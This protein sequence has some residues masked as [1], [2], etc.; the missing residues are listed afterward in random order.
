MSNY[1]IIG[2]LGVIILFLIILHKEF[3]GH[4]HYLPQPRTLYTHKF[5][6]PP[7][8]PEIKVNWDPYHEYY[9]LMQQYNK[10]VE[11]R[12]AWKQAFEEQLQ[13]FTEIIKPKTD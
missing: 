1:V 4:V 5:N 13:Q 2:F 12:D 11:E 7:E 3:K 6:L 10:L 9:E 8:R